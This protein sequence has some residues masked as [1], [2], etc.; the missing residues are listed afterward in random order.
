MT[1]GPHPFWLGSEVLVEH[2]AGD[3]LRTRLSGRRI[4][5]LAHP[6]SLDRELRPVWERIQSIP[7]VLITALF[8]PQH[9]F[10][11]DKQDNMVES[12]ESFHQELGVPIFSLYGHTRRLEREWIDLFDILLV[13]LQDVGVRVYTFLTT[14]A[15]MLE[16]L[17]TT[18]GK[19]L[20]VLDRPNPVGRVVEGHRLID[21]NE[22]FVGVAGVPMQHGM[23]LGEFA[24]YYKTTRSLDVKLEVVPMIGW[25][26]AMPWPDD[27]V[28]ILPSP[29]MPSLCTARCYPGTVMIEGVTLSEGRGT[30]R[31][32][33]MIGHPE[34][35]WHAVAAWV[36]NHFPG[37]LNGAGLRHAVFEPTFHKHAGVP[38]GGF[39]IV[40][41]RPHYD[42]NRFRP[43]RLVAAVFK[44]VRTLH[45]E[46]ELWTDPP[47]EYEETRTPIDVITGSSLLRDWVDSPATSASALETQLVADEESWRNEMVPYLLYQD[48][49]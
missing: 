23:T 37:V 48:P 15:Y 18:H 24:R 33:S 45:P 35:D 17:S 44:A 39:E 25:N 21:G 27:R 7:G 47:Y 6:A 22:S 40:A 32:L 12:A 16:D 34:V 5:I 8:G 43:Y 26:P 38:C 3:Q 41:E 1:A 9:G 11:G 20:W 19:E 42:P 28:W 4:G 46:I 13:D 30:T 31:P 14:L 29:N 2:D 36:D 49:S 10:V